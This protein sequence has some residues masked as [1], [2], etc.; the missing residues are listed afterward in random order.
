[1]TNY[2][3]P[4]NNKD[5]ITLNSGD[6]L[7][8]SARGTSSN[9]TVND[10]ATETVNS[11]GRSHITTINDGGIETVNGGA[12]V[13]QTVAE[14][15]A[16]NGGRLDL[17]HAEAINTKI[18]FLLSSPF[19]QM[20][21]LNHSLAI[22]TTISGGGLLSAEHGLVVDATSQAQGI[23]FINPG[24][25]GAGFALADPINGFKGVIAG[26]AVGDFIQLGGLSPTDNITVNS[27][28]L[29]ADHTALI[30]N[31]NNTQQ[32]T[33]HLTGMAKNTTFQLTQHTAPDG[34][35][36]SDLTVVNQPIQATAGSSEPSSPVMKIVGVADVQHDA[37][38][39]LV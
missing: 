1:M 24:G 27:F 30:V 13:T 19:S 17:N 33:Y 9:I 35:H 22:N 10:G 16:I 26:M 21:L 8:V 15:T 3:I 4:P 37:A 5:A 34:S 2:T 18:N 39:H 28:R 38:A 36:F 12:D 29:S 32:V 7:T 6:T 31:F 23:T 20:D 11:G 14:L 25:H